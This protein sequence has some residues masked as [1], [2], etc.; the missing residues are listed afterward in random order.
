MI[1]EIKGTISV[2]S[3]TT[4]KE[5][6]INSI[7]ALKR[8]KERKKTAYERF[9]TNQWFDV[10]E[11]SFYSHLHIIKSTE[12]NLHSQYIGK[13]RPSSATQE[14][15]P[16]TTMTREN[17][18]EFWRP[19]WESV[20]EVSI[21]ADWIKDTESAL[22]QHSQHPSGPIIITKEIITN[23]I[24][25]KRNWSSPG[26]DNIT[27]YWIKKMVPFMETSHQHW[28]PYSQRD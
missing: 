24:K 18:A 7:R 1:K 21:E 8:Q 15:T 23:R 28:T 11:G 14:T 12:T 27:N 6:K 2:A 20:S 22:K 3:L 19:I 5:R 13:E 10:D 25:N 9:K 26:K 4:L 17:F 16:T